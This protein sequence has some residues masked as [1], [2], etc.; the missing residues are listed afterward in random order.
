M[1]SCDATS[2]SLVFLRPERRLG[3]EMLQP[4]VAVVCALR[5]IFSERMAR[6]R[7]EYDRCDQRKRAV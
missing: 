1:T 2:N 3:N 4:V 6:K 5:L 7:A